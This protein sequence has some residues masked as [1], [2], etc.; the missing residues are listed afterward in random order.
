MRTPEAILRKKHG[1]I[2]YLHI[3]Y[4]GISPTLWV[5]LIFPY[6][7]LPD[8]HLMG[9]YHYFPTPDSGWS[10][11]HYAWMVQDHSSR[12]SRWAHPPATSFCTFN[13]QGFSLKGYPQVLPATWWWVLPIMH[14]RCYPSAI[15]SGWSALTTYQHYWLTCTIASGFHDCSR[16]SH[17]EIVGGTSYPPTNAL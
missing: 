9:P 4:V 5:I 11:I 7:Y 13:D 10:S 12:D 1:L 8:T 16:S 6:R 3:A 14:S 2:A 15:P 17:H